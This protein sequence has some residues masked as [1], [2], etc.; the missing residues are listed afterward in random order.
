M[1]A[2]EIINYLDDYIVYH[3]DKPIKVSSYLLDDDHCFL[4]NA[5]LTVIEANIL[6]GDRNDP[7]SKVLNQVYIITDIPI[8]D[9][10][11]KIITTGQLKMVLWKYVNLDGDKDV[12]LYSKYFKPNTNI[13]D[14]DSG[15][16]SEIVI[17]KEN[18][19]MEMTMFADFHYDEAQVLFSKKTGEDKFEFLP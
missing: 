1:L 16:M 15:G 3:G 6:D 11:F 17:H 9:N 2:S 14:L 18:V 13:S 10:Y 12:F 7:K 8:D 4:D 19:S 5:T